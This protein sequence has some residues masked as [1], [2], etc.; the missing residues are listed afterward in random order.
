MSLFVLKKDNLR[1]L[2]TVDLCVPCRSGVVCR[3]M[4]S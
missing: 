4:I 1:D 3:T 2:E